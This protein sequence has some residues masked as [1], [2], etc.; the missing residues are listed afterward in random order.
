M[1]PADLL[2][3]MFDATVA[4]AQPD[5][6]VP[7]YLP[8][9]PKGRTIVVGAGKASAAMAQALEARWQGPL[10]G[11]VV[12]RYGHGV[13][14]E[15]IEIVEAAHPIPDEA[16]VTAAQRILGLVS[17]LSVDDLVVALIS[18]GGSS[19]LTL[20]AVGLTL[21]EKQAVNKTLLN[22]GAPIDAMNCLRRHLSAI[23]GGRL[24]RAIAPARLESLLISDVPGD[25]P[26]LIASGPTVPDPTTFADARDIIER[27]NVAVPSVVQAHLAAAAD[28]NPKP[29]DP[30][31]SNSAVQI[32]ATPSIALAAAADV[33]RAAG[34]QVEIL[35]DAIEGE[36]RTIAEQ[37][38]HLA[39]GAA[40]GTVIL[41]GGEL[42]VTVTGSGSGSGSGGPNT[43]YA[44]ALAL[45]LDGVPDVHAMACDTDGIDGSADNAGARI[46]PDTLARAIS[47]GETPRTSL[48]I[49]NSFRV[50]E[51]LG[52]LV[53][54]GPTHT[55]VNDFRAILIDG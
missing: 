11:L 54:T 25:D 27:Y 41:S 36:A 40:P 8:A 49:N 17:G 50:F 21:A 4:A 38:A 33:A 22:S 44:L 20:P 3:Q 55:N 43:E 39:I 34:Y 53:I 18:G 45:A 42:T 52:D 47:V 30:C 35:G 31:F 14:C 19:L 37:H 28:E 48:T 16:S 46:G 7:S 24:A 2:R 51:A 15:H 6:C 26:V 29:G 12:T 23:K 9:P 13:P 1:T 5:L 32:I 10:S